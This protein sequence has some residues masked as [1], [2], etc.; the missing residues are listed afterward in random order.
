MAPWY[1][2]L[3]VRTIEMKSVLLIGGLIGGVPKFSAL[4]GAYCQGAGLWVGRAGPLPPGAD[5]E[6]AAK[7]AVTDRSHVNT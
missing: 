4:Y 1:V 5:F 7:K 6:G 2:K 3:V